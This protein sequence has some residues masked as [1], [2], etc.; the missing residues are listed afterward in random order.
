[1][2]LKRNT[3][4]PW[5]P[6]T[7]VSKLHSVAMVTC[8]MMSS[9][10]DDVRVV[11]R[12]STSWEW[13]ERYT[14]PVLRAQKQC[15]SLLKFSIAA[16]SEVREGVRK[17]SVDILD[18]LHKNLMLHIQNWINVNTKRKQGVNGVLIKEQQT[19]LA[20]NILTKTIPTNRRTNTVPWSY[21]LNPIFTGL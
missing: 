4:L 2:T 15:T 6:F 11:T 10:V 3:P 8:L 5:Y 1:M 12:C 20:R 19:N 7:D 17:K 13:L 21:P 18:I 16:M 14:Q 9:S